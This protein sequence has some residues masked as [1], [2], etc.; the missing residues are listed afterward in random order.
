MKLT[1]DMKGLDEVRR[2]IQDFSERR[3]KAAVATALTRTARGVS[4]GWQV[5]IDER[6]DRPTARTASATSFKGANA[7][8]L[9]AQAFVK[10]ALPGTSPAEYLGV[11]E[12][13][14]RRRIKKFEQALISAGAMPSGWIT[15]P[16]RGARI[17]SYGNVSRSMIIAVIAQLGSDYSPGYARVIA[18]ST[19]KRLAN[20]AKRGRAFIVVRPED[21]KQAGTDAGIYERQADG[22]R[23]AVF[24]FKRAATY[25]KRLDL[26]QAGAADLQVAL[27]REVRRAID[28]QVA[29]LAQKGAA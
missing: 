6:I 25:R 16:G 22:R 27:D 17:D 11:Q 3:M 21:V 4:T 1:I 15:V 13:G 7:G 26:L 20:A 9:E 28:E 10:D 19:A 29:R 2:S 12:A 8:R 14:G 24:L 23:K 5:Q 18:K